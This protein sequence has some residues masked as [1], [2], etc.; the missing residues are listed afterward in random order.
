MWAVE[1]LCMAE[2][3]ASKDEDKVLMVLLQSIPGKVAIAL[4]RAGDGIEV[5]CAKT[6]KTHDS[7]NLKFF[8]DFLQ[9]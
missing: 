5:A 9:N 1:P 6:R 2:S 7:T 3:L 4:V 8:Q